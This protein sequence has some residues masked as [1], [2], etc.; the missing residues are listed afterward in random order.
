MTCSESYV[1]FLVTECYSHITASMI[2]PELI[3]KHVLWYFY[4]YFSMPTP[5]DIRP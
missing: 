4:F 5:K 1:I 3:I 2:G